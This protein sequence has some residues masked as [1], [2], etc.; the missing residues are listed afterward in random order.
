MEIPK[1]WQKVCERIL[2]SPGK[3]LILGRG[4]VGK[5][6]FTTYLANEG[7]KKGLKTGV[8]DM[9]IGQS[10]IGP[11]TTMGIGILEREINSLYEVPPK[12][13]YFTGAISPA[14]PFAQKNI[15]FGLKKLLSKDFNLDLFIVESISYLRDKDFMSMLLSLEMEII[16]PKYVVIIIKPS[17]ISKNQSVDDYLSEKDTEEGGKIFTISGPEG[18][19]AKT[20]NK[21]KRFRIESWLRYLKDGKKYLVD[22][23]WDIWEGEITQLNVACGLMD[24]N[25]DYFAC[26]I[27]FGGDED[28]YYL[29]APQLAREIKKIVVGKREVEKE[30]VEFCKMAKTEEEK[31]KVFIA[32]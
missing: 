8:L 4:S 32:S 1:S 14:Y 26:G 9:D 3:V 6:F 18:I 21:R 2:S 27:L 7:Y 13:I 12:E 10:N 29:F 5:T 30:V 16:S 22:K 25:D 11:P 28:Y 23:S 20:P 17:D 19:K 15:F 31:L 24:K